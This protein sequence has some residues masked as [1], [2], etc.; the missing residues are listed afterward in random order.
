MAEIK[1]LKRGID[2]SELEQCLFANGIINHGHES[3]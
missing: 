3:T 1:K 2:Y